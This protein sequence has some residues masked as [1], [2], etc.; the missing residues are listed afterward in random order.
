MREALRTAPDGVVARSRLA[1]LL[2]GLRKVAPA[3]A[4]A[5]WRGRGLRRCYRGGGCVACSL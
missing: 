4:V 5:R 2:Q 3:G 1:P